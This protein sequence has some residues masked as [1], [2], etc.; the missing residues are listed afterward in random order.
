[1]CANAMFG[2]SLTIPTITHSQWLQIIVATSVPLVMYRITQMTKVI[3]WID[4]TVAIGLVLTPF[5][6]ILGLQGVLGGASS[7]GILSAVM[8]SSLGVIVTD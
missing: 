3:T 7:I 6:V 8:L 2:S 4:I 1:M 5:V